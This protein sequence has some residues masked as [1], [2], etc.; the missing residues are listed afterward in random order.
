MRINHSVPWLRACVIILGELKYVKEQDKKTNILPDHDLITATKA[1]LALSTLFA[2]SSLKQTTRN[3]HK[4]FLHC[5]ISKKYV[6]EISITLAPMRH[7]NTCEHEC[8][9]EN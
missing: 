7:T 4:I 2:L 9:H 6:T 3:L 1:S 8:L 5:Y